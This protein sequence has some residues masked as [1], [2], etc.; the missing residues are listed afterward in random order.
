MRIG[1]LA[2]FAGWLAH[3]STRSDQFEVA[4]STHPRPDGPQTGSS[5]TA[6]NIGM[7]STADA[8]NWG[9]TGPILRSTGAARSAQG[10]P[11]LAYAELDFEVP[12][13]IRRQLRPLLGGHVRDARVDYA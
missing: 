9:F 7:I 4:T 10:Q 11:Y 6:L 2:R 13:G 5:S 12:V 1:G 8:I 3:A